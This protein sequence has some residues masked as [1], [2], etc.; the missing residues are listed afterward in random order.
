M[1]YCSTAEGTIIAIV[2][3]DDFLSMASSK[4]KNER[5]KA[6]LCE[7]WEISEGNASF[8]L[9]MCIEWDHINRTISISQEAFID[10]ILT[11]FNLTEANPVKV[12]MNPGLRLCQPSNLSPAEKVKLSKIPYRHIVCSM[13]YLA[14]MTQLD[15]AKMY[16]DLSQ[17][18]C[19]YDQTHW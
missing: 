11:E 8:M 4:E 9:G 12:P 10:K 19:N 14:S 6:Q 16:Q 15:I 1:Y 18:L 5:F 2:H 13:G 3:I 7:C 17:F